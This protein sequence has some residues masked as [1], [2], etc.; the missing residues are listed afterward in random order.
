[1]NIPT[2]AKTGLEWATRR[3]KNT[4]KI[5]PEKYGD[6]RDVHQFLFEETSRPRFLPAMPYR[7]LAIAALTP[8]TS[9][10]RSLLSVP[11]PL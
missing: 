10:P 9:A 11:A 5:R 7:T 8:G 2:Q 6:R 1:M 4:G 3:V